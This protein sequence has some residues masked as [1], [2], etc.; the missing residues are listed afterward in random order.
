MNHDLTEQR[1]GRVEMAWQGQTLWRGLGQEMPAG[2]SLDEWRKKAGMDWTL[3]RA[4]VQFSADGVQHTFHTPGALAA[5]G[6]SAFGALAHR[7]VLYRSDTHQGLGVVS[8]RYKAV[9]PR[10]VL[11]FFNHYLDRQGFALSAAGT[12][13]GGAVLWAAARTGLTDALPGGDVVEQCLLLTTSC[14][15]TSATEARLMNLRLI[16]ANGLMGWKEK[17]RVRVPHSRQFVGNDVHAELAVLNLNERRTSFADFMAAARRL[18]ARPVSSQKA[19]DYFAAM[20]QRMRSGFMTPQFDA[21]QALADARQRAQRDA[22]EK[23]DA[24]KTMLVLFD[25]AGRGADMPGSHGTAWGLLNAVTE[26]VD[27][28]NKTKRQTPE[29]RYYSAWLGRGQT[30]KLD[31]LNLAHLV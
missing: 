6:R 26:Y 2:A 29:D 25:G 1:A 27:H 14:D 7:Q 17:T 11:D 16:C 18:A 9:Q 24:Y 30:L 10:Q 4:T 19:S 31:A 8:S 20:V 3:E 12:L 28:H 15:G 22:I 5:R 13:R 23:T 21:A